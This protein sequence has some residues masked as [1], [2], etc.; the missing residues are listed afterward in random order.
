MKTSQSTEFE[1]SLKWEE[2]VREQILDEILNLELEKIRL[3]LLL[4]FFLDISR[5]IFF[6]LVLIYWVDK[7]TLIKNL[8]KLSWQTTD[9]IMTEVKKQQHTLD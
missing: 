7:N 9:R 1:I 4:R 3:S 5:T 8:S 2:E 6:C